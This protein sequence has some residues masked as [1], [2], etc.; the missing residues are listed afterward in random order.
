MSSTEVV[1]SYLRGEISRRTLVRRLVAAGVS[2]GAAAA[3]AELLRPN[4]AFASQTAALDHYGHYNH[5]EPPP[6]QEQPTPQP[7][8]PSP[9]GPPPD[10]AGPSTAM[11]VSK[12]SLATFLVTGRLVIRFTS[13]EAST[14][15]IAAT[16]ALAKGSEAARRVVV[17]RGSA[18]FARAGSKPIRLKLTR[19]GRKALRKRR[20]ATLRLAARAVDA[21]GNASSRTL[22]LKLR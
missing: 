3:Y 6:Q 8:N 16:M 1:E 11:K 14:V 4:W 17:A 10:T 21:A 9:E 15:T 18:R 5:S 19:A 13:N 2:L 12:L 22:T 7:V 20:R